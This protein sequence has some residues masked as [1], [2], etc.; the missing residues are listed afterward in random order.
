VV[1]KPPEETT[2]IQVPRADEIKI[3][4]N[5][6]DLFQKN[7][8]GLSGKALQEQIDFFDTAFG[9]DAHKKYMPTA[10]VE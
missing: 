8:E 2:S 1:V 9:K 3:P 6:I 4:E 7:I 5:Y 10:G